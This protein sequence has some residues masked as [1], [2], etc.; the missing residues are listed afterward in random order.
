MRLG[1]KVVV[2]TGGGGGIGAAM[3]RRF[4]AEGAE[5]VVVADLDEDRAARVAEEV[6]RHGAFGLATR[7]DVGAEAEVRALAG[8]PAG[9]RPRGQR[10]AA[11]HAGAW[12][13][14]PAA[15]LLGGRAADQPGRRALHAQQA[16]R[17]RLRR[18]ARGPPRP[19]E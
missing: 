3:A 12:R 7:T 15:D 19:P 1:A 18:V 5:A 13:G 2:V 8:Q 9:P 14:L 6:G 17:G 16:R 11:G 4:A 10:R